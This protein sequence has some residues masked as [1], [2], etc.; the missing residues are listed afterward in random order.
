M[1][2]TVPLSFAAVAFGAY[3]V[4]A[5]GVGRIRRT[6]FNWIVTGAAAVVNVALNLILIPPY[7]MMG[8]AVATVAAYVTMAIGMP[9]RISPSVTRRSKI[10]R[11]C[12]NKWGILPVYHRGGEE[13][14]RAGSDNL[15]AKCESR[16]SEGS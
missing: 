15:N 1:T 9:M 12:R 7:G 6:Q 8:A 3:I 14:M 13:S 10:A 4:V 16:K 11:I 2:R 5:I